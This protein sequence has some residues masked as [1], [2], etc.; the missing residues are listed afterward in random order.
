MGCRAICEGLGWSLLT[1]RWVPGR[2]FPILIDGFLLRF[3]INGPLVLVT[4]SSC[5]MFNRICKPIVVRASD[6]PG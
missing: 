4:P 1:G 6:F 2:T 5:P 3:L